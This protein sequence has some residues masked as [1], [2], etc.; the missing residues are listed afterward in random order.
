MPT[1]AYTV[2]FS[3]SSSW[4]TP[5]GDSATYS[6]IKW[7][8]FTGYNYSVAPEAY[9]TAKP[10]DPVVAVKVPAGWG[11]PGGT[12]NV[13]I[14]AG[15]TGTADNPDHSI[16]IVDGTTAYNFWQFDRTSA[17]TATAE[18]MGKADIVTGT[19]WG[20][21]SP[22]LSAGISAAGSNQLAGLVTAADINAGT[23]NHALALQVE[24]SLAKAGHIG[25]AISGDGSS[26]S[27]LFQEGQHL[28]IP[29]DVVMP[30]G[31]SPI[32][33][34]IFHALQNYG[35]FVVDVAGGTTN[36]LAQENALTDAQ[37]NALW[38]H[39]LG[40]I[41]PLL[42]ILK[43]AGAATASG[44][45]GGTTSPAS[46]GSASSG[47]TSGNAT[48]DGTVANGTGS[49]GGTTAA[50]TN[51]DTH[52][53]GGT[54]GG[55]TTG[56]AVASD[57]GSSGG[58]TTGSGTTSPTHTGSAPDGSTGGTTSGS[59]SS[60][61]HHYLGNKYANTISGSSG[62]DFMHGQGGN[63]HLHGGA[64]NDWIFGGSGNDTM[65]GGGGR[66]F[67]FG[68]SGRDVFTNSVGATIDGGS[69]TDRLVID[70][71]FQDYKV[72]NSHGA[73]KLTNAAGDATTIKNVEQVTFSGDNST[74]NV[75]Q[76]GLQPTDL[77]H[78]IQKLMANLHSS[79]SSHA[80]TPAT[81]TSD[82]HLTELQELAL[83]SQ[84]SHGSISHVSSFGQPALATVDAHFGHQQF[85]WNVSD[86][87]HH[88]SL[89]G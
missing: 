81:G 80:F 11:Y 18:A 5:I 40:A 41:T 61:A 82:T 54:S 32:G 89:I 85:H 79:G 3:S 75:K 17:T 67:M 14:P 30:A 77:A 45:T 19:G 71:Q 42:E 26:S 33:Q 39:D 35:A 62:N 58:T 47:S 36:I 31:L 44:G 29:K 23:I 48:S 87:S 24:F 83:S 55:T 10:T 64:G 68:G 76:H 43:S 20:S 72:Q 70:G 28:A 46:S 49:T 7:P 22:F 63:D 78:G 1:T 12:V 53:T 65:S 4:N 69:G 21:S 25:Q 15:A 86:H 84:S 59:T 27:G 73:T 60:A 16:V 9:Y 34:E 8:A 66:D 2:P 50:P 52:R 38:Q 51:N 57:N 6:D 13:H 74:Y 56:G 37:S 88:D